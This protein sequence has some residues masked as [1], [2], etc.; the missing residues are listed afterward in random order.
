[1]KSLHLIGMMAL[2]VAALY[3]QQPVYWSTTQPDCSSLNNE[4]PQ[5]ITTPTGGTGYVCY[6]SGTFPWYAA[7]GG[8]STS[9][10]TWGTTI[11]V[12]GPSTNPIGVD[13][14]F[15]DVNGNSLSLD[16]TINNN[17][18]TFASGNEV[19]FALS[20]N[21]PA[22]V[23]LLGATSDAPGYTHTATGSVYA[24]FYCPDATTCSNVLPQL[25]Y[26]ALPDYPW[27]L[28]VPI[29]WDDAVWNQWSAVGI[30][31]D[32]HVVSLV[33]YNEDTVANTYTVS[34]YDVN[35]NLYGSGTTPSIPP[36][37]NLGSAGYGEGGTYGVLLSQVVSTLPTGVFKV[38][39]D[40]GQY[41]SAVDVLQV[42]GKSATTLQVAYEGS[43]PSTTATAQMARWKSVRG[44]RAAAAPKTV[45]RAL[46]K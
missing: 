17:S 13:Y 7:G 35:G 6:V 18:S 16:S 37:Q 20:A 3:S 40:G 44:S 21:Q 34:V 27:S 11:R 22:Q 31:D 1:M 29:S 5:T 2:A 26:S 28:S 10:T 46:P 36:L 9:P 4:T 12:A 8:S 14:T 23:E 45:F 39:I 30:N 38:F 41:N 25:L 15:Y 19:D 42:D 32:T 24:V 33:I 43:G